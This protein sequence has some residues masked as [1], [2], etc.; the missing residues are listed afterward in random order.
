MQNIFFFFCSYLCNHYH[1]AKDTDV[2][3]KKKKVLRKLQLKLDL[4][5]I[6]IQYTTLKKQNCLSWANF[7]F[8]NFLYFTD[9]TIIPL[10]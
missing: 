8:W 6:K 9:C 10:L 7:G 4:R 3:K 1:S 2:K 5:K